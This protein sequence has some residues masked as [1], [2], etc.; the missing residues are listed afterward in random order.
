[1]LKFHEKFTEHKTFESP[2]FFSSD[3]RRT[4][5]IEEWHMWFHQTM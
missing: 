5:N 2:Q 4:V 3:M 1:M